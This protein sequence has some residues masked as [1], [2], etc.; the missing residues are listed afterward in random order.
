MLV[1]GRLLNDL[2]KENQRL[3]L[4]LQILLNFKTVNLHVPV[5]LEQG[6]AGAKASGRNCVYLRPIALLS[7]RKEEP[8]RVTFTTLI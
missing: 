4:H 5:L 8:I 6:R 7:A 2:P 3:E 1:Q